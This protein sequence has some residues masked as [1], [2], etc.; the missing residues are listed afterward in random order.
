MLRTKNLRSR[1]Q[2]RIFLRIDI[3]AHFKILKIP[4]SFKKLLIPNYKDDFMIGVKVSIP[5][6]SYSILAEVSVIFM[7]GPKTLVNTMSWTRRRPFVGSH[8]CSTKLRT[9]TV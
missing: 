3:C 5:D 6:G 7:S 1:C 9:L 2:A 8:L 4:F